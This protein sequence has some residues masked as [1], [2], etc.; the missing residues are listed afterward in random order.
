MCIVWQ[1]EPERGARGSGELS[2]ALQQT[3]P[4]GSWAQCGQFPRI[5]EEGQRHQDRGGEQ[6]RETGDWRS[7]IRFAA[8][9]TPKPSPSTTKDQPGANTIQ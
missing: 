8:S 5:L 1:V 6:Y 3:L 9:W 7:S 2:S 4:A